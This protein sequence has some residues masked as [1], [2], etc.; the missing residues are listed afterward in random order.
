VA[1]QLALLAALVNFAFMAVYPIWS[2]IAIALAGL[3]TYSVV[4]HGAEVADAYGT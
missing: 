1:I 3:I 2:V 4:A